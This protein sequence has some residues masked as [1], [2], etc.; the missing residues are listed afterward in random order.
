MKRI[1]SAIHCVLAFV[2]AAA[3]Q[4]QQT[5]PI[6]VIARHVLDGTGK[7]IDNGVVIVEGNRITSVGAMP[8]N[9]Q[10]AC[11]PEARA[12]AERNPQRDGGK[13]KRVRSGLA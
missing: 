7:Q 9:V 5:E 4:A 12:A 3:L 11:E 1:L 8:A 13:R 10:E 6:A 2:L